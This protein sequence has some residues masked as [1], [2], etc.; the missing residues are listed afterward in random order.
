[1]EE[2]V[3]A[4]YA[5][6]ANPS[7]KDALQIAFNRAFDPK[8]DDKSVPTANLSKI[9]AEIANVGGTPLDQILR[10]LNEARR[11]IDLEG[12]KPLVLPAEEKMAALQR[13]VL[14]MVATYE[15]EFTAA[16]DRVKATKK[17]DEDLW[18]LDETVPAQKKRAEV[19]QLWGEGRYLD[20][21]RRPSQVG[22]RCR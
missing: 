20:S 9:F 15:K 12:P 21:A 19:I 3:K 5:D 1:M 13:T 18:A 16:L 7:V 17:D 22:G 11:V 4:G 6:A 8:F 14:K 10:Q 2:W